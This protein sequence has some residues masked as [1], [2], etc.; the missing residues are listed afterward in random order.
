MKKYCF[1]SAEMWK[2]WIDAKLTQNLSDVMQ[3]FE[4]F[5]EAIAEM[6]FS[7]EIWLQFCEFI[8]KHEAAFGSE[9]ASISRTYFEKAVAAV[10]CDF[11]NGSKIW[12][13]YRSVSNLSDNEI[14]SL[15]E[16]QFDLGICGIEDDWKSFVHHFPTESKTAFADYKKSCEIA[17]E[18]QKLEDALIVC[19]SSANRN[20]LVSFIS[21]SYQDSIYCEYFYEKML[22]H[23][24]N[25]RVIWQEYYSSVLVKSK[26]R[27]K[28]KFFFDR[29]LRIFHFDVEFSKLHVYFLEADGFSHSAIDDETFD[30]IIERFTVFPCFESLTQLIT[31]AFWA[32]YRLKVSADVLET[33][34]RKKKRLLENLFGAN[35]SIALKKTM[36]CFL[37]RTDMHKE[38]SKMW[39]EIVQ[40]DSENVNN[41][42]ERLKDE[43]NHVSFTKNDLSLL[44]QEATSIIPETYK[45]YF[46]SLWE[47]YEAV[48]GSS[49]SLAACKLAAIRENLKA[50]YI[51]AISNSIGTCIDVQKPKNHGPKTLTP[52]KT[53]FLSNLSW[54]SSTDDIFSFF[55]NCSDGKLLPA[56]VR[57]VL[58]SDRSSKGFAYVEFKSI[59]DAQAALLYDRK[60]LRGR[61]VFISA[62]DPKS[63]SNTQQPFKKHKHTDSKTLFIS[64]LANETDENIL[65]ETFSSA[66]SINLLRDRA[67]NSRKCAYVEYETEQEMQSI[68]KSF[69]FN[70]ETRVAHAKIQNRK[71]KIEPSDVE[72]GNREK[73]FKASQKPTRMIPAAL[74][75]KSIS[76]EK[77]QASF[78][79]DDFKKFLLQNK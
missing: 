59:E 62:Y 41:W 19:N 47:A 38:A 10:G 11:E 55:K 14:K 74:R 63:K 60:E 56:D 9:F 33:F 20:S 39:Q 45:T 42:I 3:L 15:F 48:F 22:L 51:L 13:F 2:E 50:D 68:L 58:N 30:R 76:S 17:K 67:G 6:P 40:S 70:E 26:N 46:Y 79:N 21:D 57:L 52:S 64:N 23:W 54:E 5:K 43:E 49:K 53:V 77:P 66:T 24:W 1:V 25:D 72:K 73:A 65:K 36:I 4:F 29:V 12:R 7:I 69:H 28:F 71:I 35:G 78:T 61:A 37:R 44:Y 16:R 31:C 34:Y 27:E 32:L 8:L 18:R 75:M